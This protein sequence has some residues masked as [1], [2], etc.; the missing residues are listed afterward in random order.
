MEKLPIMLDDDEEETVEDVDVTIPYWYMF[1]RRDPPQVSLLEPS[2]DI[3]HS[4]AATG[5]LPE[6]IV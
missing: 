2:H 6:L 3:L 1:N 4:D 5:L